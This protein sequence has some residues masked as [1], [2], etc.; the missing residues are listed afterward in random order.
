MRE[1]L[2]RD[3]RDLSAEF[4]RMISLNLE[5]L[6]LAGKVLLEREIDKIDAVHESNAELMNSRLNSRQN[7]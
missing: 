4:V 2:E 5:Q 3:L 7:A 1:A 6:S